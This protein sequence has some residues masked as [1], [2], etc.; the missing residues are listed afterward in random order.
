MEFLGRVLDFG[1]VIKDR[2]EIASGF[3]D[4]VKYTT[5]RIVAMRAPFWARRTT[6]AAASSCPAPRSRRRP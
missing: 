3:D 4:G 1:K 6:T 2:Q 5:D